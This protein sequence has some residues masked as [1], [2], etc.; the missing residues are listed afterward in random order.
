[1]QARERLR[2]KDKTCVLLPR[3]LFSSVESTPAGQ[4]RLLQATAEYGI[5]NVLSLNTQRFFRTAGKA[6]KKSHVYNKLGKPILQLPSGHHL[7]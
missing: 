5:D 2:W 6:H 3:L 1:M 7:I 4:R